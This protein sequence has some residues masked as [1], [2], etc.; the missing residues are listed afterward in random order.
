MRWQKEEG[1]S[2]QQGGQKE[3]ILR[4]HLVMHP[5][6]HFFISPFTNFLIIQVSIHPPISLSTWPNVY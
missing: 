4:R 3:P 2:H 1:W 6:I 5:P